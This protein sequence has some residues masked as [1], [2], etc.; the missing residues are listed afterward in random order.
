[1]RRLLPLAVATVLVAA[2]V[3]GVL[4]RTTADSSPTTEHA[5][6]IPETPRT[7]V[8]SSTMPLPSSHERRLS[9]ML[10]TGSM[11]HE[12]MMGLVLSDTECAP[13]TKMIS[14][15]RNDVRLADGSTIVLRHPHDMHTIPCLAPGEQVLLVPASA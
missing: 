10:E 12:P 6:P 7:V 4:E 9:A 13:D 1:M 8:V 3:W 2:G 11:P 5:T 15:C 14:R